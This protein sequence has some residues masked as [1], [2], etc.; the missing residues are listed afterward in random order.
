MVVHEG[1]G[2]HRFIEL[3]GVGVDPDLPEQRLHPEGAGLVG[4]DRYDLFAEYE[5]EK[6]IDHRVRR[7]CDQ[8]GGATADLGEEYRVLWSTGEKSWQPLSDLEGASEAVE[9]YR[10]THSKSML[11]EWRRASKAVGMEAPRAPDADDTVVNVDEALPLALMSRLNDL[12][13]QHAQPVSRT[14]GGCFGELKY[15]MFDPH[16]QR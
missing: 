12:K 1:V 8:Y 11:T 14:F 13:P 10:T 3:T 16:G 2:V 4:N 7:L 5:L 15:V 6:L 9:A